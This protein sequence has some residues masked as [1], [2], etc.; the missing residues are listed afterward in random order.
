MTKSHGNTVSSYL[1][2]A[3]PRYLV[4]II[5]IIL[6]ILIN[7]EV[8]LRFFFDLPLDAISELIILLFPWMSL[9]GAAVAL[10]TVGANVTLS[11]LDPRLSQRGKM[12]LRVFVSLSA[13]VFSTFMMTQGIKYATMTSGEITNVLAISMSWDTAAFPVAGV[14]FAIYSLHSIIRTL[15]RGEAGAS[16]AIAEP[17]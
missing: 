6:T 5:M 10:E 7:V 1:L 4:G 12:W 15:R 16:H 17:F 3:V 2:V 8:G 13:F 14:L 9:L 11:M